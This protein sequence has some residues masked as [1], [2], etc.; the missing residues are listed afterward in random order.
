M[1]ALEHRNVLTV[2]DS[3]VNRS[4]KEAVYITES[5]GGWTLRRHLQKLKKYRL[6][7]VKGWALQILTALDYLHSKGIVHRSVRCDNIYID[8]I[9]NDIKLGEVGLALGNY[10]NV[11][12]HF[13]HPEW[14]A[15]E[16]FEDLWT[17]SGDIYSFGMTLLEI[18][19]GRNPYSECANYLQLYRK[20]YHCGRPQTI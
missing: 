9:T 7:I 11:H 2:V 13:G 4:R 15:P 19:T 20:I 14:A 1:K 8:T 5:F 18:V 17:S 6:R 16:N 12:P 10:Y 3:W